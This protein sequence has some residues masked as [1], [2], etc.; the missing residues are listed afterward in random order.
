MRENPIPSMYTEN[1]G[2][3]Y[4]LEVTLISGP[5]ADS[6]F[7]DNPIVSRSIQ[8]RGDQTLED[9]H[10]AIFTAFDREDDSMYEFRLGKGAHDPNGGY[11]V[12]PTELSRKPTK[13]KVIAGD[14]TRTRID[15]LDLKR[16]QMFTYQFDFEDDWMHQVSVTAVDAGLPAGKFPRVISRVGES[17]AQYPDWEEEEERSQ[18]AEDEEWNVS[19]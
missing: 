10:D 16:G 5:L 13:R 4:T 17:P 6:F 15:S 11:Y 14:V 2:R 12:L 8:I 9:L 18:F 1:S 7:E 19:Y 3:C